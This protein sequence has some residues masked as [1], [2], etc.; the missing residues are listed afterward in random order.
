LRAVFEPAVPAL[1]RDVPYN[2]LT[3]QKNVEPARL[4]IRGDHRRPGAEVPPG[5]PRIA[6]PTRS[7]SE[8]VP[9]TAIAPSLTLRVGVRSELA[10]WLMHA[11]NPLTSRVI[12]NRL[13]QHHFGRGICETPSDFGLMSGSVT[14]PEL[15][16]WLAVE[17]RE[18]GWEM[19]RLHRLI[20][21][22]ATYRQRANAEF[23]LRNAESGQPETDSIP[24][25]ALPTPGSLNLI[26]FRIPHSPLRIC[27]T[28]TPASPAAAWRAKRSATRCWPRPAC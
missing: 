19:K 16:D 27:P 4:W 28:F 7:V 25:S 12:A 8:G 18:S 9:D 26:P 17:L 2:A 22:S 13:W 14:H 10:E 5:F 11:D 23:G 3:A 6:T 15:L 20:V 21:T 1:K 24:H